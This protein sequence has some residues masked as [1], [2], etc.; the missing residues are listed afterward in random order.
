MRLRILTILWPSFLMAIVLDGLVF[1][2]FDPADVGL[3]H[4]VETISPLG[5]YTMGFLLFWSVISCASGMTAL[6]VVEQ[7][8]VPAP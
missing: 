5:I 7:D 8:D 2:A 4:G 3:D 1:S 6:L